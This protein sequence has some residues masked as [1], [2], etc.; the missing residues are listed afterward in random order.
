MSAAWPPSTPATPSGN[1]LSAPVVSACHSFLGIVDVHDMLDL[2]VESYDEVCPPVRPSRCLSGGCG[3]G[4][5]HT[6]P[7]WSPS[8]GVWVCRNRL[9]G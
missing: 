2:V 6:L 9:W 3:M 4:W 8:S 7:N 5:S 1:I